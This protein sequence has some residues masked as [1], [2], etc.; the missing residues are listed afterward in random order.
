MGHKQLLMLDVSDDL[1]VE[2]EQLE[3]LESELHNMSFSACVFYVTKDKHFF[4]TMKVDGIINNLPITIL[5]DSGN[6]HNFVNCGLV[7]KSGW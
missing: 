4:Q 3:S 5:L 1:V 6:T 7:K 2:E